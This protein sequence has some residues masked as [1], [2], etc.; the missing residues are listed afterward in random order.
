MNE[1]YYSAN[2][3]KQ[4]YR[5]RIYLLMFF[6]LTVIVFYMG[7]IFHLQIT[8]GREFKNRARRVASRSIPIPAQRGEIFDR[9]HDEPLVINVD[10]FA[11]NVIPAELS[12]EELDTVALRLSQL[13]P[14][15]REEILKKIPPQYRNLYQPIEIKS[16]VSFD[17]ITRIAEHIE[18]FPGVSWQSKPIRRYLENNSLVHLIGHVGSITN[19]E[20]Q[21]LYNEGYSINS[22]IGK[23]GIEKEYDQLLRGRNGRRYNV[24]DV[25]GRQV[26][27]S[28]MTEV[29]PENGKNL[30]LTVDRDIQKLAEEALGD[31]M[32]SAIVLKPSTG[33][34]LA[35]V[36]YPW[37]DPNDFY[38]DRSDQAYRTYALDPQHPFLNR[39]IQSSYA[40]ASTF[41]IVMSTAA[42]EEEAIDP[43]KEV[44]CNG[45]M[46]VGNREFKCHEMNGHGAVNLRSGLAESCNVYFYTLGLNYLGIDII[47]KYARRFG[48]G[49]Y[50]GIDLPGEVKGLVPSP[51]WKERA[52]NSPWVGGDTVNT[53]IGQGYL[54]VT[55]IQMA[56]VIAMIANEGVIYKPHL[57]KEVHD[58]VN[59]QLIDS[60]GPEVLRN[61]SIR[62]ETFEEV[63]SNMRFA[64]TDGTAEVVITT[65]AVKIA[66]KTGTGEAGFEDSWNAWFAAYGPYNAEPEEQVVVVTMVEAGNEW[67]W[68][69]VRAA[70]IIFQG[71]FADQ[72]YDE[73]IEALNWGWLHNDRLQ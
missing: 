26:G 40:P 69:A 47:S 18:A 22:V 46:W 58:P 29:P 68:W 16:G 33:E 8:K 32:G 38:T 1:N 30:V 27:S 23:S 19:E 44:V 5:F 42:F 20:L 65:D 28:D 17:T 59:G 70:N 34:I 7:Y 62:K 13:L 51:S 9:N 60:A 49:E 43:Q 6:I 45:S 10:S 67:E 12:N 54:N 56:N 52:H 41:K 31:R 57:L 61:S 15:S 50:T 39:A 2:S 73:A 64:I 55:P 37:Y 3:I 71:I 24:V 66:G 25:R 53:S 72:N 48:Y 11:V 14:M 63:Q 4:R 21:V 35:M 36:S